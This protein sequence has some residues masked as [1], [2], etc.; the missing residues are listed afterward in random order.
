MIE[1]RKEKRRRISWGKGEKLEEVKFF[2]KSDIVKDPSGNVATNGGK[3]T[4]MQAQDD[5]IIIII[6]LI[7]TILKIR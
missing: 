4:G 2:S 5:D 3:N 6:M 7:K 1:T